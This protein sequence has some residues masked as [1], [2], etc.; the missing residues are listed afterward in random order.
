MS[1]EIIIVFTIL[2][3]A[4][5]LFATDKLRVDLIALLVMISLVLTGLVTPEEALSGFSNPA[6]VTVWAVLMLSGALSR[7]GVAN[8][9]GKRILTF[10]GKSDTRL[11]T[12]IMFAAAVLSG[13][14][15]SIAVASLF[16]PVVTDIARRTNR[17]RSK[18]LLPLAYAALLGG[19]MTLIGTPPNLLVSQALSDAGLEPFRMFDFT[20]IGSIIMVIGVFFMVFL[21]KRFLPSRDIT[22]DFSPEGDIKYRDIFELQDRM[23]IISINKNSPLVGRS[24]IES[25]LGIALGLNVIAILKE[26]KKILSP[27]PETILQSGDRLLV[28]GKTDLLEEGLA[29]ENLII[30]DEKLAVEAL[31]SAKIKLMEIKILPGSFLAGKTLSQIDFRNR[32]G[33]IVLAIRKGGEIKRT[34]LETFILDS[35][36]TLLIQASKEQIEKMEEAD[37]NVVIQPSKEQVYHLE[38]DLV[39]VRLALDS[40]LVGKTLTES[41]L[42]DAYG[43]GVMGIMREGKLQLMPAADSKLQAGDH[44]L[45]KGNKEDLAKITGLQKLRVEKETLPEMEKLE[46]EKVG[47][48]EAII[49]PFATLAGK[50]LDEL[51]FRTKYGLNVLAIWRGGR[52]YRSNLRNMALQFGDALLLY[53][54]RENARVLGSDPDFLVLTESAQAPFRIKKAPVA[55]LI[56]IGVLVSVISGWLTITVAAIAGVALMV[57][58]KTLTME[59]AYQAVQWQVI[60]MI[61]GMLPLGIAMENSGVAQFIADA[62]LALFGKSGGLAVMAGFFILA[63]V[64]TQVIPNAAVALLLAPIAISSAERFGISPYPLMMTIAIAS[65][66]AFLSPIGHPTTVLV[67]GPGGYRFKDYLNVGIPLTLVIFLA[68]MLLLPIFWPL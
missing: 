30:E 43:L 65:S 68:V 59:E 21:G 19:L 7:T 39:M 20:P 11:L 26:D 53:G 66:T 63:T 2:G 23:K 22:R 51:H 56:M 48:V 13:F 10:V 67:M 1:L 34:N 60:F 29:S 6:V 15:N 42:G 62:I 38:A 24:L 50:T 55:V 46:S 12:A 64:G 8:L 27:S 18:L 52:P 16:L 35:G 45:I 32:F 9:I 40:Y 31:S 47:L 28:E 37:L 14:M 44:L 49:S 5:L 25:R 61:A 41:R 3:S 36:D 54:Q 33:A 17:Y 4:T 57:L 58:T